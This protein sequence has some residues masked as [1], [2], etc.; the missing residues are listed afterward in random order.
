VRRPQRF[1]WSSS[2]SLYQPSFLRSVIF[3]F[4]LILVRRCCSETIIFWR[5][6]SW[7]KSKGTVTG[8]NIQSHNFRHFSISYLGFEFAHIP[9][10][11]QTN[12]TMKFATILTFSASA[13]GLAFDGP[14]PT[15][16]TDFVYAAL[17]GFTPKPT[18]Q[19]RA[20][21]E[22]FRRQKAASNPAVCGYLDGD[23]GMSAPL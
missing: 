10:S 15:P 9:T 17:N 8:R 6:L 18:N 11:K 13:Y 3:V 22:L 5:W 2:F 12:I 21:P 20:L 14:L 4:L 19:V 23:V 16:V 7:V 1:D